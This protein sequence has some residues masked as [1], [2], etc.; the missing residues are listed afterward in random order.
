MLGGYGGV[1]NHDLLSLEEE[2]DRVT[3]V[4]GSYGDGFWSEPRVY[5]LL[6]KITVEFQ[7]KGENWRILNIIRESVN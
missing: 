1:R 4:L 5:H 3:V 2:G 7:L 6:E